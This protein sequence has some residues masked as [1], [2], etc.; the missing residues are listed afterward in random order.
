[1]EESRMKI[2]LYQKELLFFR[3]QEIN[4]A[5]KYIELNTNISKEIICNYDNNNKEISQISKEKLVKNKND[6]LNIRKLKDQLDF[7]REELN[8]EVNVFYN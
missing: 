2:K 5:N 6:F 7:R 3:E 8:N 4:F 1:M